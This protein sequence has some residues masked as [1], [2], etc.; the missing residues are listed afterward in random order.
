V[1]IMFPIR[2]VTMA[3]SIF[4]APLVVG[5]SVNLGTPRNIPNAAVM[6]V[7]ALREVVAVQGLA[8]VLLRPIAI[9]TRSI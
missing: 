6:G 3:T 7:A 4:Q 1:A 5:A 8:Q 9:Q 2:N